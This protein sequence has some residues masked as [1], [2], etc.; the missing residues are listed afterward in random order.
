M[1]MGSLHVLDDIVD[2]GLGGKARAVGIGWRAHGL[3]EIVIIRLQLKMESEAGN[4]EFDVLTVDRLEEIARNRG[5]VLIGGDPGGQ[6]RPA[7]EV[8]AVVVPE[9][10]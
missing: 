7:K 3:D 4:A 5:V 8:Q 1:R 2:F 10:K 6:L 9:E